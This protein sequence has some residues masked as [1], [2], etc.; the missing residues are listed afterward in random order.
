[1]LIGTLDCR[2]SGRG[3]SFHYIG[4]EH[5]SIP[6]ASVFTSSRGWV[7]PP[8]HGDCAL[9]AIQSNTHIGA[10]YKLD[11]VDL[12]LWIQ[13]SGLSSRLYRF[14]CSQQGTK[15]IRKQPTAYV[16]RLRKPSRDLDQ[17]DAPNVHLCS[18]QWLRN[19]VS[20]VWVSRRSSWC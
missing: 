15:W 20:L 3:P 7:Y 14:V 9:S 19:I 5:A 11:C 13:S 2:L 1:M 10:D 8:V 12:L 17:P 16:E 4:P 18:T 6:E